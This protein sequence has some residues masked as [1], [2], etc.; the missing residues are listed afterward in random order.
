MDPNA[1]HPECGR[2]A[3]EPLRDPASFGRVSI[4]RSL[5]W[6]DGADFA[7]EFLHERVS[8]GRRRDP[9]G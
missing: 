3:F 8:A 1:P 7:P 9:D 4:D 5:V 2:E 6:P